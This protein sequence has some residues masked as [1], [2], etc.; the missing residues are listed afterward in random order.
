[1][2]LLQTLKRDVA[3]PFVQQR[4]L[5][6]DFI[7]ILPADEYRVQIVSRVG[8][9]EQ[10]LKKTASELVDLVDSKFLSYANLAGACIFARPKNRQ[11]ILL[12]DL[13]P[14]EAERLVEPGFD[15]VL[16]I[17]SSPHKTNCILRIRELDPNPAPAREAAD[18]AEMHKR[19]QKLIVEELRGAGLNVDI[20]A[21]RDMQ[22]WRLPGF[23]NQKRPKENVAELKYGP[24]CYTEIQKASPGA[25]PRRG[26]EFVARAGRNRSRTASRASADERLVR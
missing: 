24:G 1:M 5:V 7:R 8:G 20:G 14:L 26:A 11:Y 9:D 17:K 16:V 6:R 15:P 19:V 3:S 4:R 10:H 21:A 2:S 23:S 22:V 18:A 25:V 12:D 13:S